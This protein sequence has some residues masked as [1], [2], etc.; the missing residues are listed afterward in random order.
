MSEEIT[1]K[2]QDLWK[3]STFVLVAI[4]LI[5]GVFLFTGNPSGN[6]VN[7][8]NSEVSGVVSASID[9][10]AVLG[11]P[12]APVII[13]EFSDF[14]CPYCKRHHDQT[15]P[16]IKE[17]YIDT[18]KVKYVFRDFTPTLI[19]PEYHPN[20]INAAMAT[21]CVREQ[22]GDGSYW[23]MSDKIFANQGFNSVDNLKTLANDLGYDISS[24]L[25]SEKYKNEVVKDFTDGQ[26]AGIQGTPGFIIMGKDGKGELISGAYPFSAFQQVIES[27]LS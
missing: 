17:E 19:N 2:K 4:V 8:G 12:N 21:E 16:L 9:D 13:I 7:T 1:I 10:D 11:D 27:K 24:C 20:A 18:G 26:S 6:A 3:Y 23:D 25:S 15:F 14:E 5:G 22:G